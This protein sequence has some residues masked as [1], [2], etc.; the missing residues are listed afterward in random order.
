MLLELE[1]I[2]KTLVNEGFPDG[3]LHGLLNYYPS[4]NAFGDYDY[5]PLIKVFKY[6]YSIWTVICGSC[7]KEE[8]KDY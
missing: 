8:K 3:N 4:V 6:S 2:S 1:C 7:T 5:I